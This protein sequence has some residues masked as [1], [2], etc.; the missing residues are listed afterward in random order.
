[1]ECG[2]RLTDRDYAPSEDEDFSLED[3][4]LCPDGNCT[5]IIIDGRCTECGKSPEE[6]PSA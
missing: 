2:A 5:G 1:M 3:R 4:V 6:H